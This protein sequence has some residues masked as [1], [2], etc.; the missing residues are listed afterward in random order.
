MMERRSV[1]NYLNIC[2]HEEN[3]TNII[4]LPGIKNKAAKFYPPT[5]EE[6]FCKNELKKPERSDVKLRDILCKTFN[7]YQYVVQYDSSNDQI[8]TKHQ[9][10]IKIGCFAVAKK[11]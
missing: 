9:V 10:K 6:K 8:V 1:D 3:T 5:V 2:S 11:I 4:D 7:S